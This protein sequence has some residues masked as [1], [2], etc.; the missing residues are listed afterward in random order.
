MLSGCYQ[1][2][3]M[4]EGASSTLQISYCSDSTSALPL[5]PPCASPCQASALFKS[6]AH[7]VFFTDMPMR[8]YGGTPLSYACCFD[9]RKAILAYLQTELVSLNDRSDACVISGYLPIH[10]VTASSLEGTYE[11]ITKELPEHYRADVTQR[12]SIGRMPEINVHG[13]LPL[14]L[15]AKLGDHDLVKFM[16]RK[17]CSVLWVWGPVTMHSINLAGID[18]AGDGNGDIMELVTRMDAD[19][20]CTSLLLDEFMQGLV[21]KLFLDKWKLFGSKLH[22]A[23][24]LVDFLIL[25]L[26]VMMAMTLK[27]SVDNQPTMQPVAIAILAL[28]ACKGRLTRLSSTHLSSTRHSSTRLTSTHLSSA[29]PTRL[30]PHTLPPHLHT[31]SLLRLS[32]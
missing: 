23:R 26:L 1:S 9:L 21:Y 8:M 3:S 6:Q 19:T 7:G 20:G 25:G 31:S 18:S 30:P 4:R 12:S 13:L 22:Y 16:L 24:R 14:Q 29:R 32:T 17:Q 28:Q 27:F 5:T 10:A 15:A 11:Y 2:I